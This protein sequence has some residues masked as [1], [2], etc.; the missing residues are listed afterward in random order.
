[1]KSGASLF[2]LWEQRG[3]ASEMP[4]ISLTLVQTWLQQTSKSGWKVLPSREVIF[5]VVNVEL[6]PGT[7]VAPQ[8]GHKSNTFNKSHTCQ[9]YTGIQ[10]KNTAFFNYTSWLFS[11]CNNYV[12]FEGWYFIHHTQLF[13]STVLLKS[14]CFWSKSSSTATAAKCSICDCFSFSYSTFYCVNCDVLAS[15]AVRYES[16]E[17]S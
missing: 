1:M 14:I 3:N 16:Q 2:S 12:Y 13:Y 8:S 7:C 9:F 4:R 6:P 10:I 11:W 5:H 17:R 15:D